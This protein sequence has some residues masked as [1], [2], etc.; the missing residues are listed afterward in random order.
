MTS[1]RAR[2]IGITDYPNDP[3]TKKDLNKIAQVL[4]VPYTAELKKKLNDAARKYLS[5]KQTFDTKERL[6][7]VRDD[8]RKVSRQSQKLVD[9][10]KGLSPTAR[11]AMKLSVS[12]LEAIEVDVHRLKNAADF[13]LDNLPHDKRGAPKI[14][15]K[16]L[17]ED[18]IKI[19]VLTTGKKAGLSR[20]PDSTDYKGPFFRFANAF[21][22]RI[23][24][25]E[26]GQKLGDQIRAVSRSL[27][28]ECLHPDPA[29]KSST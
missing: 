26:S 9:I 15:L 11:A 6:A 4:G 24:H 29:K 5:A 14:A 28:S 19:Y 16:A 13:A 2:F 25:E 18:L 22:E 21:L 17:I 20:P 12:D 23:D 7:P 10:F 3:F 8:L 27:P 1:K